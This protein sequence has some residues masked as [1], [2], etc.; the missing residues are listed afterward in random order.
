MTECTLCDLRS[1]ALIIIS[2]KPLLQLSGDIRQPM[3]MIFI[4]RSAAT[5]SYADIIRVTMYDN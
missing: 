5:K 4:K 3:L 2:K 1:D